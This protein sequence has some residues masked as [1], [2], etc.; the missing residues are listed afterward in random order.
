[1]RSRGQDLLET[2][3][4]AAYHAPNHGP[5]RSGPALP[6][7][8]AWTHTPSHS[9]RGPDSRLRAS[10][11][12]STVHT[13]TSS[14]KALPYIFV[15]IILARLLNFTFISL[16]LIL[17]NSILD[18]M[19]R[20]ARQYIRCPVRFEL[21]VK[22]YFFVWECLKYFTRH[23]YTKK[24]YMFF[25]WNSSGH[26]VFSFAIVNVSALP[27]RDVKNPLVPRSSLARKRHSTNIWWIDGCNFYSCRLS[28]ELNL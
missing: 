5:S 24:S 2:L 7:A 8:F 15:C 21:Q 12:S 19:I 23:T 14:R 17:L 13:F 16:F 22:Y 27:A 10:G 9:P 28:Q 11:Y 1:M 3:P 25:I 20:D 4:D 6:C 18:P 26:L